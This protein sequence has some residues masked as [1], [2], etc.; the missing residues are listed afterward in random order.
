MSKQTVEENTKTKQRS[1]HIYIHTQ[2]CIVIYLLIYSHKNNYTKKKYIYTGQDKMLHSKKKK[3]FNLKLFTLREVH[4]SH[5]F[6]LSPDFRH[7]A[8]SKPCLTN[9]YINSNFGKLKYVRKH[10]HLNSGKYEL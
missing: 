8:T 10:F 6:R 9:H 2:T 4:I 7:C 3:I 1:M 5:I